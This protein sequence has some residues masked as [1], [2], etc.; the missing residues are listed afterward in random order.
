MCL[1]LAAGNN[2]WSRGMALLEARQIPAIGA[3]TMYS[4]LFRCDRRSAGEVGCRAD[5]G[6]PI[7]TGRRFEFVHSPSSVDEYY[8]RNWVALLR[9]KRAATLAVVRVAN[10]FYDAV[11]ENVHQLAKDYH[12]E[13]IY[14]ALVPSQGVA[15]SEA[16]ALSFTRALAAVAADGVVL[17]VIDCSPWLQAMYALDY[18]P[19][20]VISLNCVDNSGSHPLLERNFI[21]GAVQ[22][23]ARLEGS[24]FTEQVTDAWAHYTPASGSSISTSPSLFVQDWRRHYNS[25]DTPGYLYAFT[26][27]GLEML[28]AAVVLAN[29]TDGAQVNA[30]LR[31]LAQPSFFGMLQTNAFGFNQYKP[32]LI[33]QQDHDGVTQIVGQSAFSVSSV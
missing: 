21:A 8:L 32:L 16:T 33:L 4:S 11:E 15:V 24:E 26:I 12:M 27:G 22:W 23:D 28:E 25:T 7:T 17:L 19:P 14:S 31:T 3:G 6:A 1:W 29:T 10:V 30:Q 18:M 9:V 5:N 20:A 2:F 13:V